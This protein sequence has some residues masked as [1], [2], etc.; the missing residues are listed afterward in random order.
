MTGAFQA[1]ATT[2]GDVAL[3]WAQGTTNAYDT[4]LLEGSWM[5]ISKMH[6]E[7]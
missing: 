7:N 1:N 6:D 4:K 3:Q 2:G 5:R